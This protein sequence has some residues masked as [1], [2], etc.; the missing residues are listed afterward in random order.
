MLTLFTLGGVVGGYLFRYGDRLGNRIFP[1]IFLICA[2][3]FGIILRAKGLVGMIAGAVVFG[4][5]YGL[6][7]AGIMIAAGYAVPQAIRPGVTARLLASAGLGE[8]LSSFIMAAAV[9]LFGCTYERFPFF[10][11]MVIYLL[12]AAGFFAAYLGKGNGSAD[13][14]IAA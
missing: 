9:K 4:I 3:G 12:L 8:F 1:L 13:D 2:A 5:G 14:E 7:M 10:I 6:F 11:S